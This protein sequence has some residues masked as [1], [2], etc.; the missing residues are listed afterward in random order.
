MSIGPATMKSALPG[1][2]ITGTPLASADLARSG[3]A[4]HRPLLRKSL[5]STSEVSTTAQPDLDAQGINGA[6][7]REGAPAATHRRSP[8]DFAAAGRGVEAARETL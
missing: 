2:K 6:A 1:A 5:I 4:L 7:N 8:R 3:P